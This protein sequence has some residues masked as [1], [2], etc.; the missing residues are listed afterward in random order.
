MPYPFYYQASQIR[1]T[2]DGTVT[3]QL[4][5]SCKVD[6]AKLKAALTVLDAKGE[7][8]AVEI[9]PDKDD[10]LVTRVKAY[11]KPEKLGQVT[12]TLPENFLSTRSARA[13]VLPR[14][15][16]AISKSAPPTPR[17]WTRSSSTSTSRRP[18]T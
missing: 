6:L 11:V 14:R 2:A 10:P 18:R 8:L 15:G 1:Y 5:F 12:V 4:D 3:L 13:R 16:S 17:T 7:K 9:E